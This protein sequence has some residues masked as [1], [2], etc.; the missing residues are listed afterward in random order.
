MKTIVLLFVSILLASCNEGLPKTEQ[1][2]EPY[3]VYKEKENKTLTDIAY[4]LLRFEKYEMALELIQGDTSITANDI[5]S[6]VFEARGQYK[7]AI[8]LDI[9]NLRQYDGEEF[10]EGSWILCDLYELCLNK[11]DYSIALLEKEIERSKSNYQTRLLM[12]KL[13]WTSGDDLALVVKLG[14][15]FR[16]ELPDMSSEVSFNHWRDD[17]LDSLAIK[18]PEVYESIMSSYKPAPWNGVEV[19][20]N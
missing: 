3:I 6:R 13:L 17:A 15:D 12:M 5:R 11:I 4:D 9:R 18:Q 8:E 10:F 20:H 1:V 7:E 19:R 14:D 16:K 2:K